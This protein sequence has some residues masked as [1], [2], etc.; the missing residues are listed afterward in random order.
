MIQ[1]CRRRDAWL[2]FL[3]SFLALYFELI[4]I[5]WLSSEVRVFAYLKNLPLIAS[6]LGLGLGCAAARSGKDAFNKLP[7]AL[8]ILCLVIAFSA[9]LGITF[10]P[11]PISDY[12]IVGDVTG[13]FDYSSLANKL[14]ALAKFLAVVMCI[15]AICAYVFLALGQKLGQLLDRFDPLKSYT[16]NVGGSLAGVIAF[17]LISFAGWPPLAWFALGFGLLLGFLD[18]KR[19]GG[20]TLGLS[21]L[22]IA[23]VPGRALWSP[24]YRIDVTPMRADD[25]NPS[26]PVVGH[27]LNVNHDYHQRM[28]NL[29]EGSFETDFTVKAR[30]YYNLIYRFVR[31]QKVLVVG[32]GSGNDV[33]A[34]LRNGA[35]QVDA[36]EIDP[37]ILKLGKQLHPEQPYD[38]SRVRVFN[39]DARAFFKLS[40]E[41]YD[42]IVF[43]LLDSQTLLSSMSSIRLDNYIYTQESLKEALDHLRQG[44]TL[45]L[46]FAL[47][48][49]WIQERFYRMLKEA[50]Q[51]EPLCLQT[52][53]DAGIS[54][55]VGPSA[56][57][58]WVRGKTDLEA[59][60]INDRIPNTETPL[61][62][63]D[64][65]FLYLRHKSIPFAYWFT[66]SVLFLVGAFWIRKTLAASETPFNGYFFLLGAGFML[67]E[68]KSISDLSLL[69]GSTWLVNSVVIAS[70]LF[71]I[72]IANLLVAKLKCTAAN[73]AYVGLAACLLFS[74]FLKPAALAGLGILSKV[75]MGGLV[76]GLPLFFAGIL[77]ATAF[78]KVQNV[79]S[80][81][82]ANLLG[83]LVGGV[84]ENLA[85]I[86]GV[87]FLN[88]LALGIYLVSI[89][90][91]YRPDWYWLRASKALL[92]EK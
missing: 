34:A 4:V 82:G 42:L 50:A 19:V 80:A 81:F 23:A 46:S 48:E 41:K 71:M 16:L 76:S 3:V 8:G 67:I 56:N 44:G 68:V 39:N 27:N 31:P 89:P 87:A 37:L 92:P 91:Q 6:F 2:L 72:L 73:W 74:Y 14:W 77:F 62:T 33:A 54:Y 83:A 49:I 60:V 9:Q 85:M 38:S 84:L 43:G 55:I 63:D 15:C 1:T 86:Y 61:P 28:L 79:P 65:P 5:R 30:P 12:L 17:S 22:A 21:L 29:A 47:T 52:P 25:S 53:Y 26:S 69:F 36:V 18:N 40:Q 11:F 90:V 58:E 45:S 66:L 51:S 70:I 88:L 32:A 10:L 59:M 64:W 35:T 78:K 57:R 24:Y 7:L 20:L 13:G 75:L